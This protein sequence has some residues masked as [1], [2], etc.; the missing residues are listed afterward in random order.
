ML[1]Y[2]SIDRHSHF[3]ALLDT[4]LPR[5]VGLVTGYVAGQRVLDSAQMSHR[6][7]PAHIDPWECK[8]I[9]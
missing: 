1:I 4:Y 3:R 5:F 8:L 6:P 9:P 2:P 7:K